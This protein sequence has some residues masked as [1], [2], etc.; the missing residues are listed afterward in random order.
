MTNPGASSAPTETIVRRRSRTPIYAAIAIV[1]IL[2]I[3][4]AGFSAGWFK[5]SSSVLS[6]TCAPPSGVNLLGAGSSLVYPLMYQWES[7]YGGGTTVNY[8]SVGSSSG[9]TD[10]SGHTVA[11]GASDAPLNPAQRVAVPGLQTIPESAGGVVPIYNVPGATT[12]SFN[13]TV[14]AGIY[15]GLIDSW[16]APAIQALNPGVSLPAHSIQVV[17]RSDG[18]G[19][20]FIWT[21]YLSLENSTWKNTIG[22]GLEVDFP[23]GSGEPKN[24][25]VAGFVLS[26]PYTMGYVDLNYALN[27]SIQ[28]GKVQNPMGH[29]ILANVTNTASALGDADLTLP[30]GGGDWYNVSLL[31]APG[32]DDYPITSLTYV[33]VYQDQSSYPG[34]YTLS[35]A[36]ALVDFLYWAVTVGQSYSAQINYVPL[37]SY[38]VSADEMSIGSLTYDGSTVP[39][40]CGSSD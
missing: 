11:F 19:T 33:L 40:S 29:F 36:E 5:P 13:G 24:A 3:V 27:G 38:I 17:Y 9:I 32:P 35:D 39:N 4:V 6:G 2:V 16:N 15:L 20:T 12:L 28:Y 25:G 23:V 26:T 30:P 31:N 1:V 7:V 8:A 21:S 14:L 22:K 34:S 18:S 37:P 10:I